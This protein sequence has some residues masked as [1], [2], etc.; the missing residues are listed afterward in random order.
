MSLRQQLE[1]RCWLHD[2]QLQR[3]SATSGSSTLIFVESKISNENRK[4]SAPTSGNF[5][6]AHLGM[7]YWTTCL[8]LHQTLWHL[9]SH[10]RTKLPKHTDPRQSCRKIVLLMPYFQCANMGDF[11]MNITAFPAMSATRF[12]DRHDPPDHPSKERRILLKTFRGKY[13]RRME[14]FLGTWPWRSSKWK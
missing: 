7:L 10:N 3:W 14:N 2:A 13:Q 6:M 11:F 9:N 5:A 8:I 4:S 1:G 12:L